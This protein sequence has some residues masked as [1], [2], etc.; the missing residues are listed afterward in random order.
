VL[1]RSA[2]RRTL[3]SGAAAALADECLR[4]SGRRWLAIALRLSPTRA[5]LDLVER[6]LIPGL[7][8]H[9]AARKAFIEGR[10]R[11]AVRDGPGQLVVLG[12][13]FDA[14]GATL[15]AEG[16]P[17]IEM[18]RAPTQA[19]KRAA[20]ERLG[21]LKPALRLWPADLEGYIHARLPEGSTVIAEG[22]L[23]YLPRQRAEALLT[24]LHARGASCL[25]ATF[26]THRDGRGEPAFEGVSGLVNRWMAIRGERF[27][28]AAEPGEF[29]D[30][31]A[32]CG[33][34]V[35]DIAQSPEL[36][37]QVLGPRGLGGR[38]LVAGEAIAVAEPA[39]AGATR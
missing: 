16:I 23:M 20:L 31:L 34:R 2:D 8:L 36:R 6:A 25:I 28:W 32:R 13:G 21:M 3:V 29:R 12:A 33:W 35:R 17:A 24:S 19:I 10:A 4:L 15:A 22:L 39:R 37:D 27:L 1:R 30:M 5:G 38:R 26:M 9:H 11:T 7:T 18:D 14:L